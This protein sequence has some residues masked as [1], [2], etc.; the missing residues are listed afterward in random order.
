MK[1]GLQVGKTKVFLRAHAYEVIEQLRHVHMERSAVT[2]QA[3]GLM[4]IQRRDYMQVKSA[5]IVVQCA[6][7]SMIAKKFVQEKRVRHNATIIQKMRRRMVCKRTYL[8]TI[9]AARWVQ[10]A[11]RGQKARDI[12]NQ[13]LR[14]RKA[15][16]IQTWWRKARLASLYKLQKSSA[17]NLQCAWRCAV[18]RKLLKDLKKKQRDLNA[19][20]G[21]RDALKAEVQA[22][23]KALDK[24][25]QQAK[26]SEERTKAAI[27]SSQ[28]A[29]GTMVE[30]SILEAMRKE[31]DHFSQR[32]NAEEK[33]RIDEKALLESELAEKNLLIQE[34]D[35]AK[36]EIKNLR[37]ELVGLKEDETNQETR[38]NMLQNTVQHLKDI[39]S[40]LEEDKNFLLREKEEMELRISCLQEEVAAASEAVPPPNTVSPCEID[41]TEE[42]INDL[43]DE[44]NRLQAA[45]QE[46]ELKET[47]VVSSDAYKALEKEKNMLNEEIE[48]SQN[49]HKQ[50][51]AKSSEKL[52]EALCRMMELESELELAKKKGK[53]IRAHYSAMPAP[54]GMMGCGDAEEVEYLQ[55]E[56]IR[57]EQELA[58][59]KKIIP[60]EE[61]RPAPVEEFNPNSPEHLI[62]R[63]EELRKLS[64]ANVAKDRELEILRQENKALKEKSRRK[65]DYD[66]SDNDNPYD[67]DDTSSLGF[68]D[69][70]DRPN[71]RA[72]AKSRVDEND[73]FATFNDRKQKSKRRASLTGNVRYEDYEALQAVNQMLRN[74]VDRLT[75]DLADTKKTAEKERAQAEADLEAF[76]EALRGVDEMRRAAEAMS[77]ELTK[78]RRRKRLSR[79]NSSQW[80]TMSMR[81]DVSVMSGATEM[82]DEAQRILHRSNRHANRTQNLFT[83][84][85]GGWG[86]GQLKEDGDN[87]A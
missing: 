55:N 11:K 40:E 56:I 5:I 64:E 72:A 69:T 1:V 75:K 8:A 2:I 82:I 7:R 68:S 79:E 28:A 15:T 61:P 77:R 67:N 81:D 47:D 83:K 59:A 19:I 12:F 57:L 17:F 29:I 22:L 70:A 80:E 71:E 85:R 14:Q 26:V 84:I 23:K 65:D 46:Q 54:P 60:R 20:G 49:L 37:K 43:H 25:K 30:A 31:R 45:L 13:L 38:L 62:A 48:K 63:Y 24:A 58:D 36:C 39:V 51:L 42:E 3:L 53:D 74:E 52:E 78:H 35:T 6:L 50:E 33:H 10:R 34:L 73:P 41:P 27:A 18:A 44:I 4:H 16:I 87:N 76:S 86:M 32:L 66:V 21:E 9:Y